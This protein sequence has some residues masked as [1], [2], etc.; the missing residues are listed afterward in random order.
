M[1]P[2][3]FSCR[4]TEDDPALVTELLQKLE[5][6]EI[7]NL[8]FRVAGNNDHITI[9]GYVADRN[10]ARSL[11]LELRWVAQNHGAKKFDYTYD[12]CPHTD[13]DKE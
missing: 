3:F 1:Y 4:R 10:E 2:F 13:E 11:C 6:P 5:L 8:S 7:E 9:V 12:I